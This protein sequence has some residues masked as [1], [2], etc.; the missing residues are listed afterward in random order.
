MEEIYEK[1]ASKVYK[2]IYAL[3]RNN[4]LTE[5]I[6]QDTFYSAIKN[7]NNFKQDSSMYTWLCVI[8]KNKWKDYLKRKNKLEFI[9]YEEELIKDKSIQN[10]D[11]REEILRL[12]EAMHAL[13]SITKEI[14]LIRLHT[15]LSFKEIG[16]LFGKSE[17]WARTNF[18]R[19]KLKI[20]EELKD[21]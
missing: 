4:E 12:Y 13:D 14:V 3:C 21:E 2:Y 7:I 17:Q 10:T 20:R 6:L 11:N 16:G 1:Y 15:D 5:E 8:A 18:Y 9:P 19:G